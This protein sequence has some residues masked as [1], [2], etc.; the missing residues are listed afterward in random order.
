MANPRYAELLGHIN[1]AEHR[2]RECAEFLEDVPNLLFKETS[3]NVTVLE[4]EYRQHTGDLDCVTIGEVTDESGVNCIRAYVWELKA[5]QCYVFKEDQHNAN[6]LVPTDSLIQAE[7]QLLNYH[8][9]LMGSTRF[10]GEYGI[11]HPENVRLGGIIIGRLDR[12]VQGPSDDD[13]K[14]RLYESAIRCR[15]RFYSSSGIRLMLWNVVLEHLQVPTP[16]E[17]IIPPEMTLDETP[18]ITEGTIATFGD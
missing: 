17:P 14:N 13:R 7:N 12:T 6:R 18:E 10:R 16:P 5:P 15:N 2:E 1:H 11:T 3:V 9:E 8:D 4:P